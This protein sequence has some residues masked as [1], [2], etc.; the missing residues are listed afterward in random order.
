M[1]TFLSV[2]GIVKS[3]GWFLPLVM[4]VLKHQFLYRFYNSINIAMSIIVTYNATT[5]FEIFK[6]ADYTIHIERFEF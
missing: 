3:G 4:E 5:G 1:Q 2:K 6:P